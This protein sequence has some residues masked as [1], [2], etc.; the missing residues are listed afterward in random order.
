[1]RDDSTIS[2]RLGGFLEYN[3]MSLGFSSLYPLGMGL[4]GLAFLC[5]LRTRKAAQVQAE[6][7]AVEHKQAA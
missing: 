6:P 2:S 4:Y 7:P 1:M 5:L 3:S